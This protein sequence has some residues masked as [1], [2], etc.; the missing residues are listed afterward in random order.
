MQH[1]CVDFTTGCSPGI[2]LLAGL[3]DRCGAVPTRRKH[4]LPTKEIPMSSNGNGSGKQTSNDARS[5]SLN[6]NNPAYQASEAN[7][8]N[9]LNPD[10]VAYESSREGSAP[11]SEKK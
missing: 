2:L 11:Q 1:A 7:R 6:P 3:G 4:E 8:A 5:N 9:Q 10:H